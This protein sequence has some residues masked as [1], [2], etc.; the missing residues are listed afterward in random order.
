MSFRVRMAD[1]ATDEAHLKSI[2]F[3]VFCVEQ[4]VPEALEWD[5]LDAQCLHAIAEDGQGTAI[6]CG[7]LLPDGHIGRLAVRAQWRALGVGSALLEKLVA[8]ATK[9][10]D[11]K[12]MLNAQTHAMPFY[13]RF[14]FKPV[15]E[16]F[17]EAGLPHQ[18]MEARLP[19]R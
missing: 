18:A 10:G 8:I 2:R 12:A 11:A 7:R 9:R 19:V 5:G 3:E 4:G 15:G 17:D 16:P 14:G 1:W 13:A 6:G